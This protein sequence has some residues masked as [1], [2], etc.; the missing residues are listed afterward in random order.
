ML[1]MAKRDALLNSLADLINK[2]KRGE[3]LRVAVDGIDCAGKT[4]LADELMPLVEDRGRPVIRASLDGF[5][6]SSHVRYARGRESPEGYYLDSFNYQGLVDKLLLPLSQGGDHRYI[7]AI[8]DYRKDEPVELQPKEADPEA[9]LLLDGVFL[10]RPELLSFWDLKIFL[11]ISYEES[12][13]RAIVRNGG[14][15]SKVEDLYLR[16]YIPGQKL[17]MIHSAPKRKTDILIDNNVPANPRITYLN[18]D[19]GLVDQ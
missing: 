10:L 17:Y 13:K 14:V 11:D 12:M 8:F 2:M 15:G 4:M 3:I 1:S 6:N 18:K 9:V 5:H 19:L 7:E 16:R